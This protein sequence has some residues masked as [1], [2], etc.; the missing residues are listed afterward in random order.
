LVPA[1]PL[2]RC[3]PVIWRYDEIRPFVMESGKLITAEEPSA[4][5]W[6][7]EN[8]GLSESRQVTNSSSGVQLLLPGEVA[9][10]I[11]TRHRLCDS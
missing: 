1:E 2:T 10:R 4:A 7:L 8:P 11:G 3:V 5:S 6:F 9:P